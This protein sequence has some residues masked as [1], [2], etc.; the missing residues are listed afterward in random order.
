MVVLLFERVPDLLDHGRAVRLLVSGG[1]SPDDGSLVGPFHPVGE[2]QTGYQKLRASDTAAH[3][4]I[5]DVEVTT[6]DVKVQHELIA[7]VGLADLAGGGLVVVA[8]IDIPV[9]H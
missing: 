3:D 8:L 4:L 5:V 1:A 9:P 6:S 7:D 2:S